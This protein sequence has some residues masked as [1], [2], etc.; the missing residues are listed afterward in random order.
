[1]AYIALLIANILLALPF[2]LSILSP[3]MYKSA[4]RYDK[5]CASL[6]IKGWRRFKEIEFPYLKSSLAYVFALAFCFSLGDLG[7]IALFGNEDISTLPWY[8]YGLLGSY[9]SS[10]GA[11]VALVML[12]L[13]LGVFV[14]VPRIF[15]KKAS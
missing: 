1:M 14:V 13:V 8:L 15:G 9:R 6:G 3:L 7:V 10:D 4:T 12:V 2:S 5:L 11:G